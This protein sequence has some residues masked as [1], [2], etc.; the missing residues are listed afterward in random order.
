[1]KRT[2]LVQWLKAWS[3]LVALVTVAPLIVVILGLT[4]CVRHPVG[5]PEQSKVDPAY[6]GVWSMKDADGER[7]LLFF[8]PYDTRTYFI[9][10]FSY[11]SDGDRVTPTQRM[12]CKGWLTAIGGAT[13]LTMEPLNCEHFAGAGEKPPY[14]V[15]KI[16][17]VD[18]T[19]RLHF[20]N[21]DQ[22]PVKSANSS[23]ALEAAIAQSI[24]SESLYGGEAA[25]LT[26]VDDKTLVK[27]VLEAF[28]PAGCLE[29]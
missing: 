5:D 19:L 22:E 7:S 1:M 3:P 21:G 13:F 23:Q 17:L 4:A 8:R 10:I 24:N 6:D 25:V 16:G 11:R 18:G 15:G 29:W 2:R 14:L 26:K 12:N 27:S 20:V 9:N 28:R